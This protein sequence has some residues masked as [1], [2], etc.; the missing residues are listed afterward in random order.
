MKSNMKVCSNGHQCDS[1][2][3]SDSECEYDSCSED[4]MSE[5]DSDMS[6][7]ERYER[8]RTN[9]NNFISWWKRNNKSVAPK[10]VT[11][12]KVPNSVLKATVPTEPVIVFKKKEFSWGVVSQPKVEKIEA[13][14]IDQKKNENDEE[15]TTVSYK[16]T[17]KTNEEKVDNRIRR[18]KMCDSI[19]NHTVCKHG[20]NCRF[21]HTVDELEYP[22]CSYGSN[23]ALVKASSDISVYRNVHP[24]KICGRIHPN[25]TDDTF[26]TR[27]TGI[28]KR[29]TKEEMDDAYHEFLEALKKPEIPKVSV[30]KKNMFVRQ[31]YTCPWPSSFERFKECDIDKLLFIARVNNIQT[32]HQVKTNRKYM[33]V[34]KTD[35]MLFLDLMKLAEKRYKVDTDDITEFKTMLLKK[36]EKINTAINKKKDVLKEDV[37]TTQIR[38]KNLLTVEIRSV[39]NSIEKN[40][41]TIGRLSNIKENKEFNKK[42]IQKIPSLIKSEKER[43][44]GL[45]QRLVDFQDIKKFEE[46][47]KSKEVKVVEKVEVAVPEKKQVVKSI[48]DVTIVLIMP[49]KTKVEVSEPV[50]VKTVTVED[51]GWVTVSYKKKE[52]VV[53]LP[54]QVPVPAVAKRTCESVIK[55]VPCRHG[56]KCRFSHEKLQIAIEQKPEVKSWNNVAKSNVPFK[57]LPVKAQTQVVNTENTKTK[58]CDSV[59]KGIPCRHG[60]YCRFAHDKKELVRRKCRYGDN[61]YNVSTCE[62]AH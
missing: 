31:Q 8:Y 41:K 11:T 10:P 35:T 19:R 50:Q 58:M 7:G 46:Y 62:F 13:L 26:Y 42:Q 38:E 49:A 30:P 15:W 22:I 47:L 17:A 60:K 4:Y 3:D 39:N 27:T 21:A 53:H 14:I 5:Y 55:G 61:C 43:L 16:K 51:I 52:K 36:Q 28:A 24:R 20:K 1:E 59:I 9:F 48:E 34:R 57:P 54:V 44:K 12:P 18:S 37:K 29:A 45:E 25:E 33:S 6:E 56:D 40:E 23:C 32:H 2:Y